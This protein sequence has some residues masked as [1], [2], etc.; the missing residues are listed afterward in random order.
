M[1]VSQVLVY[2]LD[3]LARDCVADRILA[4]TWTLIEN[5]SHLFI[6]F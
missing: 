4:A 5:F 3:L 2:S 6:H 1:S